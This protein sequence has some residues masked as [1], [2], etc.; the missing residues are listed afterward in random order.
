MH[1]KDSAEPPR[2]EE[3]ERGGG[4]R[5]RREEEEERRRV[6]CR[7][8]E[9]YGATLFSCFG[10]TSLFVCT[11][12]LFMYLFL[13]VKDQTNSRDMSFLQSSLLLL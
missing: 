10:F 6:Q 4:E 3:E 8:G 2:T 5:R 1:Q 13:Q 9:V 12:P 11:V 7:R